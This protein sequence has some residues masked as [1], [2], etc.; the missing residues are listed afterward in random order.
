MTYDLMIER[1]ID[2][3]AS[4]V[5]DAFL[6]PKAQAKLYDDPTD[7]NWVVESELD[8]RVGGTWTI[9]FGTAGKEPYRETNVFT[10][11]ER[12][13]R[14][15]F[16]STMVM[17]DDGPVISTKVMVTFEDAGGKTLMTMRQ[18]GFDRE[19]DRDGIEGGWPS[20]LDA[21]ERVVASRKKNRAQTG[22]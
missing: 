4:A 2:G 11:V 14:L 21:L 13:R 8:L 12:P 20:I 3:P 9:A 15:V 16:D 22:I 17:S 5:F 18:S 10:E 7:P 19:E 6:D 1:L